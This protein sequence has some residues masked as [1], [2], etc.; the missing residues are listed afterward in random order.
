[1]NRQAATELPPPWARLKES[2]F[3]V[4]D[5]DRLIDEALAGHS[6]AFGQLV[7]IY[8]DR[9]FNTIFHVTG[10]AE[11]ARDIVQEALVQAYVKL[12]AFRHH[13]AFYTWLYRIAFN[14]AMTHRRRKR[15]TM[16]IDQMR[17]T[18]H[19]G[20]GGPGGRSGR[21][22]GPKGSC[23]SG[24]GQ[25]IARLQAEEHRAVLVLR[26][27]DGCCYEAISEILDLPVGHGSQPPA[28][29]HLQLRED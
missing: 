4:S 21:C 8:Q 26:E 9:L 20:A 22:P 14:V 25:A 12:D 2:E 11:D 19:R 17:E 13:S 7:L 18:S 28:Q 5:D 6:E 23:G 1:M 27:I 29:A 16:S 15:P 3:G 24:A 10:N